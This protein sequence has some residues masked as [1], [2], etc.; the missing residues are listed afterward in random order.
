MSKVCDIVDVVEPVE[1]FAKE[2]REAKL[3]GKGKIGEVYVTGLQHWEPKEEYD[4]AWNQWCLGHLTD[5][6]LVTYLRKCRG[7]VKEGGGL[8]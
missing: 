3:A 6:E 7:M 5:T 2:A 8:L 1:K 4:L